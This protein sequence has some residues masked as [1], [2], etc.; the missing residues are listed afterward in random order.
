M[1]S[2]FIQELKV[3]QD[4]LDVTQAHLRAATRELAEQRKQIQLCQSRCN[5]FDQVSQRVRNLAKAIADEDKFDWS[6]R[7]SV[8]RRDGSNSNTSDHRQ[9]EFIFPAVIQGAHAPPSRLDEPPPIPAENSMAALVRLRR[10]KRWQDRTEQLIHERVKTLQG[11][12]LTKELQAKKLVSICSNVSL[13]KVD[14]VRA[15][16]VIPMANPPD[17]GFVATRRSSLVV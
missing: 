7:D 5:E 14:E 10:L 12:S 11:V 4:T 17:S 13:D 1:N 2:E 3:K 9:Q 8:D 6:G 16:L 15:I